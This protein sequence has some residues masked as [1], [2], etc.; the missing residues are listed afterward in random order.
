MKIKTTTLS[1]AA[2]ALLSIGASV[3]IAGDRGPINFTS[4]PALTGSMALDAGGYSA[5]TREHLTQATAFFVAHIEQP[6]GSAHPAFGANPLGVYV[7]KTMSGRLVV[8]PMEIRH[9]DFERPRVN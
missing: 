6:D 5:T 8:R 7:F 4:E 9:T 1:I 2:I 3:S